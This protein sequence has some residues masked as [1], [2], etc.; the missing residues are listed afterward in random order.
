MTDA[1]I[2]EVKDL[3]RYLY[4]ANPSVT[5]SR[6]ASGG[7]LGSISDTRQ[8]SGTATTDVTDFDNADET[9]NISTVTV[10]YAHISESRV[11]TAPV[12][13]SIAGKI[14]VSYISVSV[15]A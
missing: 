9:P 10:N 11:N 7:T 13:V 2:N 4:G 8:K 1:E 15:I 6:V 14:N 12:I 5:L 3:C